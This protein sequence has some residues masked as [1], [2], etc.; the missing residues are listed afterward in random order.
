MRHAYSFPDGSLYKY[1]KFDGF[2]LLMSFCT[3]LVMNIELLGLKNISIGSSGVSEVEAS[4][5]PHKVVDVKP[6]KSFSIF[7]QWG[8]DMSNQKLATCPNC[9]VIDDWIASSTKYGN[10]P[11]GW[12]CEAPIKVDG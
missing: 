7:H 8:V 9:G 10:Q 2:S 12:E 1:A 4:E 5:N 3:L 11:R 6:L